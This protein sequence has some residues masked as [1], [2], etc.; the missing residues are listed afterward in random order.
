MVEE[1][2]AATHSLRQEAKNVVLAV[3]SFN[4]GKIAKSRAGASPVKAPAT[5]KAS[6]IKNNWRGGSAA[7]ATALSPD[8]Q[9]NLDDWTDF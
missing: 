1:T 6:G 2:T 7:A 5:P 9:A 3:E 8:P 4:I